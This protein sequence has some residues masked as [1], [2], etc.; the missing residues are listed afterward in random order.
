MKLKRI[1]SKSEKSVIFPIMMKYPETVNLKGRKDTSA[2]P[3]RKPL[4]TIHAHFATT[5]REV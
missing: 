2:S 5:V 1:D 3:V 4:Q